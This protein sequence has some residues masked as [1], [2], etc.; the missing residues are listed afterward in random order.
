MQKG[1]KRCAK[2]GCRKLAIGAGISNL[3]PVHDEERINSEDPYAG[4]TRMTEL[5]AEKWGRLDAEIRSLGYQLKA[6]KYEVRF[7]EIDEVARRQQAQLVEEER[8]R[9]VELAEEA[10]RQQYELEE[11]EARKGHSVLQIQHYQ[12][13][14]EIEEQVEELKEIY[15]ANTTSLAEKYKIDRSKM[16]IDIDSRVIREVDIE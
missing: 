2:E 4:M 9:Q 3:C 14:K 16:V 7:A 11:Q 10:R 5:E 13:I 1:R 8:Q 12:R 6:E 15:K